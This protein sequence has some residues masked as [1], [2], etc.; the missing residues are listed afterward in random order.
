MKDDTF[1][2]PGGDFH[3]FM[4][5]TNKLPQPSNSPLK[6]Q[7]MCPHFVNVLTLSTIYTGP[8]YVTNTSTRTHTQT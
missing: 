3:I 1:E 6:Q 7:T 4:G 2:T 8:H 5:K